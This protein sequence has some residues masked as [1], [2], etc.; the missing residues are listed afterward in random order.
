MY[1]RL[2]MQKHLE[3]VAGVGHVYFQPPA[4]VRM[5]YPCVVYELDR[6]DK[7]PADDCTYSLALG[8]TVTVIDKNPDSELAK[9]VSSLRYCSFDRGYTKDNLYHYVFTLYH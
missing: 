5:Q 7:R 4:S 1:R 3:K 2:E 8:Y 9:K 6:V